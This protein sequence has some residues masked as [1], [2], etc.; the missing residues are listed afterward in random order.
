MTG[1]ASFCGTKIL[2]FSPLPG[3]IEFSF[4]S[5]FLLFLFFPDFVGEFCFLRPFLGENKDS[6]GWQ[7]GKAVFDAF[8]A[9]GDCMTLLFGDIRVLYPRGIFAGESKLCELT[10]SAPLTLRFSKKEFNKGFLFLKDPCFYI[11]FSN[12]AR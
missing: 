4:S 10:I 3:E 8:G 9:S 12:S 7:R 1:L 6:K 5:F 2:R 11:C